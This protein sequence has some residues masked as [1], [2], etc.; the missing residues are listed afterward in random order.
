M[1]RLLAHISLFLMALLIS[2]PVIAQDDSTTNMDCDS[3]EA[4]IK[5]EISPALCYPKSDYPTYNDA[6]EQMFKDV[7]GF[8]SCNNTCQLPALFD[9]KPIRT[10]WLQE[11]DYEETDTHHC[12]SGTLN[13]K[14]KCSPCERKR[15]VVDD[16]VPVGDGASEGGDPSYAINDIQKSLNEGKIGSINKVFPNPTNGVFHFQ[17]N[18]HQNESTVELMVHDQQGSQ[19]YFKDYQQ[20]PESVFRAQGDL[21]TLPNGYYFLTIKINGE[22]VSRASIVVQQ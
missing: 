2:V 17:I 12:F 11:L 9:C 16:P 20:V 10:Q 3:E 19:V 5:M 7:M 22:A 18:V 8:V 21:S 15:V 13:F 14:W 6:K 4:E 1:N